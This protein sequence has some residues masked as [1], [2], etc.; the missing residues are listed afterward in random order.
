[1]LSAYECQSTTIPS[2]N[3]QKK[4]N[5][6]NNNRD[7]VCIFILGILTL[8]V[9]FS[10]IC[11]FKY[12]LRDKFVY[13]ELVDY[14]DKTVSISKI[15][16]NPTLGIYELRP[17]EMEILGE[18]RKYKSL[19]WTFFFVDISSL[20]FFGVSA[21]FFFSVQQSKGIIR[22]LF[23]IFSIFGFLYCLIELG[24]FTILISPFS[25]RLPNATIALLDHAIP[26]NPGGLAQIE[27]RFNCIFDQNLYDTFKR[28]SNPKNTCDPLLLNS[29]IPNILLGI[30]IAI[31]I[32]FVS[33][34][35]IL[36]FTPNSSLNRSITNLILRLKPAI[37]YR[38]NKS[39]R[40]NQ[41][42]K[43]KLPSY[44]ASPA[45]T[46]FSVKEPSAPQHS[47]LPTN[48]PPITPPIGHI[49][50]SIN[51]NNAALFAVSGAINYGGGGGGSRSCSDI[52]IA[53]CGNYS[54]QDLTIRGST[55]T[56]NSLVSE[57]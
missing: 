29:F 15:N 28:H 19:I 46:T 11:I 18:Q 54:T 12:A 37:H 16:F 5:N 14:L 22:A 10:S 52:S 47:P 49:D 35:I 24:V 51:Y 43:N 56:T 7:C 41:Q 36:L 42:Q 55:H 26:Y 9:I 53:K 33:T 13:D 4:E 48:I 1:M 30:F 50:H 21:F 6:S 57:V 25:T 32:F 44:Y 8:A 2:I 20:I 39:E 38:K 45:K 17:N 40:N 23:W 34:L 3:P 31:R 27:S